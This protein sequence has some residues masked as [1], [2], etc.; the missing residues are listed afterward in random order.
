MA[1][2]SMVGFALPAGNTITTASGSFFMPWGGSFATA[3]V[4]E[5]RAQI[6]NRGGG[7]L[8]NVYLTVTTNA[9]TASTYKDRKNTANG[10]ISISVT[11]S[12]PGTYL[13]TTHT[14]SYADGDL[15]CSNIVLGTGT[16]AF[17]ANLRVTGEFVCAS[18]AF[19]QLV[20][21]TAGTLTTGST[22]FIA[23]G[24]LGPNGASTTEANRQHKAQ[25]AFT[26]SHL[27]I[28]VNTNAGTI[29]GTGVFRNNGVTGNQSIPITA[30]TAGLY[31]D[32]TH[33]DS[34]LANSTFSCLITAGTG[35]ST[36][37]DFVG[38]TYTGG[39]SGQAMHAYGYSMGTASTSAAFTGLF[40]NTVTL[41]GGSTE[42]Q[43]QTP[44]PF[45]GTWNHLCVF[46][47]AAGTGNQTITDR[48]NTAAGNQSIV[49]TGTGYGQD[50][51][52]STSFN[53]ADKLAV[54]YI[55]AT[56][57]A[58]YTTMSGLFV[59]PVTS[60]DVLFGQAVM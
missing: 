39:V 26:A 20:G 4:T 36:S 1:Q 16:G 21:N 54:S 34:V 30:L 22:N 9:H 53:P 3:A 44:S 15:W 10:N 33:S 19:T 25:E 57:G 12:T 35:G 47:A 29:G 60:A 49:I 6:T 45:G 42:A 40:G 43:V 31:E 51:T 56:A 28:H 5:A 13:D 8:Q 14:T 38:V 17:G 37:V 41:G 32:T 11:A 48:V 18:Q 23:F 55:A 2:S 27:Q 58:T 46:I 59:G 7:T 52:H 24:G 50:T